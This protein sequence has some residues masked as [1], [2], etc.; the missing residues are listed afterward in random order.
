MISL[1]SQ[2]WV[3]KAVNKNAEL[4]GNLEN[5]NFS[6]DEINLSLMILEN[7]V[8]KENPDEKKFIFIL[9]AAY[10]LG[11]YYYL[12]NNFNKMKTFFD[13]CIAKKQSLK[14]LE[15]I[16]FDIDDLNSLLQ[17]YLSENKDDFHANKNDKINKGSQSLFYEIDNLEE[18]ICGNDVEMLV[19]QEDSENKKLESESEPRYQST[20]DNQ[21]IANI[22][23]EMSIGKNNLTGENKILNIDK[24]DSSQ[25]CY[26]IIDFSENNK[27][28]QILKNDLINFFN[29]NN[30]LSVAEKS[31]VEVSNFY[32]NKKFTL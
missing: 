16:Y 14:S 31:L 15:L 2:F 10:E 11:M 29:K 20:Q 28:D 9:K 22:D 30:T 3:I 12:H 26:K 6:Q 24:V 19:L 8:F 25:Y 27:I 32:I 17:L 4:T 1:K 18:K 5:P 21:A 7:D 13:F 23:V